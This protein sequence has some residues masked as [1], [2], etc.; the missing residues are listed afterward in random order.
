MA[1]TDPQG[2]ERDFIQYPGTC[3]PHDVHG[4]TVISSDVSDHGW[5]KK[6]NI[7]YR[8]EVIPTPVTDDPITEPAELAML[9][10]PSVNMVDAL[11][12]DAEAVVTHLPSLFENPDSVTTKSRTSLTQLAEAKIDDHLDVFDTPMEDHAFV[13]ALLEK[14]EES[15]V[16]LPALSDNII[17]ESLH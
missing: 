5:L 13:S 16:S 17:F 9:K 15:S 14:A 10:A 8:I 3:V 7:T 4:D 2:V 1:C 11:S 6:S 12:H